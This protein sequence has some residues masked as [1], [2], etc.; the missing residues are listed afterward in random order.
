MLKKF[1]IFILILNVSMVVHAVP[2][3]YPVTAEMQLRKGRGWS[4]FTIFNTEN[5]KKIYKIDIRDVDN[6]GEKS[7]LSKSLKIF[8]KYIEVLPRKNQV[9]KLMVKDF[10]V[11]EMKDGEYRASI[12]I[13]ELSSGLDK[14]YQQKNKI[15]GIS[16]VINFKYQVNMGIYGYVGKLSPSINVNVKFIKGKT[17]YATITNRGNYSYP[18]K[19]QLLNKKYEVIEDVFMPKLME[20]EIK[21]VQIKILGE[22]VKLKIIEGRSKESLYEY[23]I[24]S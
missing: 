17:L 19:Y 12:S 22:A 4:K 10:P 11:D 24:K 3:I 14:K 6:L 7:L 8:P 15:D 5:E 23:N 1:F 9:V 2:N 18:I 20:G 21:N 16:T 13:E